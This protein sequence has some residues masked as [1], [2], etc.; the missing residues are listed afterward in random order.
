MVVGEIPAGRQL[1]HLCRNRLCVNPAHLEPVT[2]RTNTLRGN[3]PNAII[4][5]TKRCKHGHSMRDARVTKKGRDCRRCHNLR[6]KAYRTA[7]QE[8]SRG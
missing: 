5:R 8:V 7:K 4:H 3:S 1:D 2:N 6:A